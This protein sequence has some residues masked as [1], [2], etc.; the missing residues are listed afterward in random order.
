MSKLINIFKDQPSLLKKCWHGLEKE[1]LRTNTAGQLSTKQH[2]EKL[3][4]ALTH[5]NYT[6]DFSEA[7]LEFVTEPFSNV[8]KAYRS[9]E[10]LHAFAYRSLGSELLW[11]HSVPCTVPDV[12]QV[13]LA[14]FGDTQKGY[15]KWLYRQGLSYRC[16]KKMQ[17]M[18]G[19]HYNFSWDT[20]FWEYY[21]QRAQ[22][23]R[24]LREFISENY[25][26]LARNYLRYGW[27]ISY[28][29][30][31]SPILDE[32]YLDDLE[33]PFKSWMRKSI[34]APFATSVR[35]SHF[36][37]F[38]KIQNQLRIS[39]NSLDEYLKD[40]QYALTTP[41]PFYQRIGKMQNNKQV[42]INENFLQIEAE[43]YTRIRPKPDPKLIDRPLLALEKGIFYFE[44]RNIDICPSCP[45]GIDIELL[46]FLHV[47]FIYCLNKESPLLDKE[48][49]KQVCQHQ[50]QVA[51]FGRNPKLKLNDFKSS[52]D[53]LMRDFA[54]EICDELIPIAHLLDDSKKLYSK[55]LQEQINKVLDVTLTP[56]HQ[57]LERIQQKKMEFQDYITWMA[58][59]H[60][61]AFLSKPLSQAFEHKMQK[62]SRISIEQLIEMEKEDEDF[63]P[64][65]EDMEFSTQMLM[66]EAHRSHYSVRILDRTR[67]IIEISS[68]QKSVM[69]KQATQSSKDTLMSYLIME[70]KYVTQ[71]LLK[72]K[73]LATTHA[74][75]FN[76]PE[77]ALKRY[78]VFSHLKLV[79]KPNHANYGSHIFFIEPHQKK[80]FKQACT[81][82]HALG[83]QILVE[84]F[85]QGDEYRFLI[86]GKKVIAI[87]HRKPPYIVGDG[88]H[89]IQ[90]LIE[91]KNQHNEKRRGF[92]KPITLDY[93]LEKR[94]E[95][96]SLNF[97]S[98]LP[99]QEQINLRQNSNVS[100]GG[101]SV[102]VSDIMHPDYQTIALKAAQVVEAKICGV[103]ML[104]QK[105]R[106][107]ATPTNHVILELNHNPALYIHRYPSQGPKRYVEKDLLKFLM[108]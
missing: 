69:V 75:L 42:Q 1:S 49:A 9:L 105:P 19:V 80:D 48:E 81:S 52:K 6:L 106:S 43:H 71:T 108:S 27:L 44:V 16:G 23:T 63:F 82:I 20:T 92:Q 78:S 101:E 30:G 33:A 90:E 53:R 50:D 99:A 61:K 98:V 3:G 97:Q 31:A 100:T 94:L 10:D 24:P 4:A 25:L 57:Q 45:F 77:E 26:A 91:K 14:H 103:D 59:E 18:S 37:Y 54:R 76:L 87:A 84:P 55:S 56:S 32:T 29:F 60:K 67:N 8:E 39:F 85:F 102:D 58:K 104:I 72:E 21:Y 51:L 36:G 107:R 96:M 15:E 40:L 68:P 38:S 83:D 88:Q 79:A 17:L 62:L 64:G 73:M 13:L 28:L 34:Y 86:I 46:R 7:Q 74:E 47:F 89:T 93:E 66:K 5:P 12:E 35:M 41:H 11:P 65:Y 22:D 2:P 70:N 95:V